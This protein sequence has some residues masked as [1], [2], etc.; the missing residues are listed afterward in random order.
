MDSRSSRS[1]NDREPLWGPLKEYPFSSRSDV[2]KFSEMVIRLTI[3]TKGQSFEL[4][5]VLKF[6]R[7]VI[8]LTINTKGQS[9]ELEQRYF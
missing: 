8:R 9:F 4:E 1:T 2:L 6:I 5:H 3:H 7:M